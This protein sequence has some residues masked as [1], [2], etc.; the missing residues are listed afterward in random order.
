MLIALHD[1][2]AKHNSV[3]ILAGVVVEDWFG[4]PLPLDGVKST[5][6]VYKEVHEVVAE[7]YACF[8]EEDKHACHLELYPRPNGELYVCGCGGSDYVRG[9]RLRA[10]GDCARA[11]QV[12]SLI[13][14][15][16]S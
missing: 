2:S 16:Y 1:N 12:M 9:D 15:Q 11:E 8:C 6:L 14:L 3:N 10:G 5:S 13:K 4:L 7:P